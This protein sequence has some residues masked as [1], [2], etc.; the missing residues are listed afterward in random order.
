MEW[1]FYIVWSAIILQLLF[2]YHCLRNYLYAL[3]KYKKKRTRQQGPAVLIIPCKGIDQNFHK[4]ITSFYH[5]DYENYELWFV[6]GEE[7]DPAYA[8]LCKLKQKLSQNTKAKDVQIFIAGQGQ[9]CSQKM[10][11]LLYC[12]DKVTDDIDFLAFA[13]SDIYARSDWLN[14]IVW[15]LRKE[16]YGVASGYRWLVPEQTNPPTLILSALNAK[17]AQLLGYSRFNQVWGGSTAIR[18]DTFRKLQ[19]DKIWSKALTDDLTLSS[20]VKKTGKLVAF[21]PACLVASFEYTGWKEMFE[22]AR[23]Q[24]FITRLYAPYTWW[25][26]LLGSLY[27]VL[28]LYGGTVMAVY[29]AAKGS[30]HLPLFSSVPIIFL[31]SQLSRAVLRQKM[32]AKLLSDYREQLKPAAILDILGCWLWSPI[33]LILILSSAYVRTIKWRGIKYRVTSHDEIIVIGE[34]S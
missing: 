30:E 9:S 26:G 27:S 14:H 19:I 3:S 6:V 32:I 15:P 22:F 16:K 23:R 24:F 25:F 4:N 11:N 29:A 31:A 17:V 7:S 34:Q 33:M 18:A 20:A 28:G 1:Y 12:Y 10:H 8:E 13:D 2:L 5:Q 21:V